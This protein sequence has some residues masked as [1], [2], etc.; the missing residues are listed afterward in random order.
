MSTTSIEHLSNEFFYEIFDYL[1]A[2]DIYDAFSNLNYRFQQ[3]LDNSSILYKIKLIDRSISNVVLI[4]TWTKIGHLNR[5]QVFSIHLFMSTNINQM[6]STLF[7]DS[8]LHRLQ[9]LVL[10]EP[11]PDTLMS[12][13]G[14]LIDLP[15]LCSL[16][17]KELRH[18]KDLTDIYRL[19]LAL[20]MLTYYKIS[21]STMYSNVSIPLPMS[22]KT[23]PL[24]YL[25]IND[26]CTFNELSTILSYTPYLC[27]LNFTE[28]DKN[29]APIRMIIPSIPIHLTYLRVHLCHVTF[30]EFEIFIRQSRP[31]L[32]ILMFST[33]LEEVAYMDAYR[34]EQ[35]IVQD[36]PQLEKFSLRYHERN[37]D[38]DQS[39][40]HFEESNPFFSSFWLERQWMFET[41]IIAEYFIYSVRPYKY[42][43]KNFSFKTK[44]FVPFRKRW[45]EEPNVDNPTMEF[46]KSV[47]L[48]IPHIS[49]DEYY[50]LVVTDIETVLS[51]TQIHHLEISEKVGI[52]ILVQFTNALPKVTTM[53][54]HSLSLDKARDTETEELIVFPSRRSINQIRKIYL[55]T[56]SNIKEIYSLMKRYR[57]MS[58]LQINSFDNIDVDVF[59]LNILTKINRDSKQHLRSLCFRAPATASDA[60]IVHTVKR[61]KTDYTIN[62]VDGYIFLQWK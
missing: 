29:N 35:L 5:K 57:N 34:W 48:T 59:M 37:D 41:E 16:T 17:I 26:P 23:S 24:E 62:R 21:T 51:V 52:D 60:L 9:S 42:I 1:N 39:N 38:K 20:P 12:I 43:P 61:M 46:S 49:L 33:S 50:H 10:I 56:V 58:H 8:S 14:K 54:L 31:K 36:L 40:I 19:I 27:H 45:Y 4:K 13:L 25:I 22:T 28:S 2:W 15:R 44:S 53:K 55:E 32:K 47:R 6:A 11:E 3:L 30:D 7:I 18:L